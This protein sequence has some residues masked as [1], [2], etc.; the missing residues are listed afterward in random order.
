MRRVEAVVAETVAREAVGR[1]VARVIHLVAEQIGHRVL[2]LGAIQPSQD[3]PAL[4]A[5]P[6]LAD[7]IDGG[8]QHGDGA[9]PAGRLRMGSALGRH[10]AALHSVEDV[11]PDLGGAPALGDVVRKVIEPQLGQLNLGAVAGVAV[12]FEQR[13]DFDNGL[14][15]LGRTAAADSKPAGEDHRGDEQVGE[16]HFQGSVY[17]TRV[18]LWTG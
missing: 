8:L 10:L 4:G 7:A 11:T 12:V 15:I 3:R 5:A 9:V 2:V 1:N 18:P 14:G 6:L 13:T 16:L 17:S